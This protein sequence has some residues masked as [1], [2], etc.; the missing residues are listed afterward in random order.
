[1]LI[2]TSS[3]SR[4]HRSLGR[5][6]CERNSFPSNRRRLYRLEVFSLLFF[7]EHRVELLL[8]QRKN[9]QSVQQRVAALRLQNPPATSLLLVKDGSRPTLP[10][11][12]VLV[13]WLPKARWWAESGWNSTAQGNAILRPND[14]QFVL[15]FFLLNKA[16]VSQI[17]L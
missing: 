5:G 14:T 17:H 4:R 13:V 2:C 15:Q 8:I 12:T 7:I 3:L 16:S 9:Q 11:R 1:M 10:A 6:S